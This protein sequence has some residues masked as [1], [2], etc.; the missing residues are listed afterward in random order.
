MRIA[1]TRFVLLA[2]AFSLAAFLLEPATAQAAQKKASGGREAAVRECTV[3]MDAQ[4][5]RGIPGSGAP[6]RRTAL[7]KDCMRRVGYRP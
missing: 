6:E 7:F 2:S 3:R 5:P 4:Q 1:N